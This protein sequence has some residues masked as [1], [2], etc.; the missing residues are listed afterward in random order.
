LRVRTQCIAGLLWLSLFMPTSASAEQITPE[1]VQQHFQTARQLAFDGDYR[2]AI[3]IY[4]QLLALQADNVDYLLGLGQALVWNKQEAQA[5]PYLNTAVA[6]APDYEQIYQVL[7]HAYTA[8][9]NREQAETIRLAAQERFRQ[10]A[11]T[12]EVTDTSTLP[13]TTSYKLHLANQVEILGN[14]RNDWRYTT[15][16]MNA[17]FSN[18]R[19]L[20]IN[21]LHTE[22]FQLNDT[23]VSIYGNYPLTS[24]WMLHAVIDYS[25]THKVMPH[26]VGYVQLGY[27]FNNGWGLLAGG[28]LARYTESSVRRADLTVEYYIASLRLAYTVAFNDAS[29]AGN[30]NNHRVQ[31]GYYLDSGSNIQL[32]F[33]SGNEVE[34]TIGSDRIIRTGIET[35]ALW[36]ETRLHD[37]WGILYAAGYLGLRPDQLQKTSRKFASLGVSYFF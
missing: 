30:A 27:N 28:K 19:Q 20:G 7:F 10:P 25:P 5:I 35:I 1:T 14:D 6:L 26:G 9:N 24:N 12:H 33:I 18:N 17:R 16:G 21:L 15:L 32:S 22:K 23:T 37:R 3:D 4:R 31:I 11:W 36:G 2:A 8:T 34:K 29:N 13:S